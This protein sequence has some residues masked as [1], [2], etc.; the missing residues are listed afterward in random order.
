[1]YTLEKGVQNYMK[2]KDTELWEGS[3]FVFDGRMAIRPGVCSFAFCMACVCLSL[4]TAC[5]Q[6][7]Q[8]Q[9]SYMKATVVPAA[10]MGIPF[11]SRMLRHAASTYLLC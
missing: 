4:A 1:M 3:L 11:L 8:P 6:Q 5:M 9:H 2:Q 7:A 10:F